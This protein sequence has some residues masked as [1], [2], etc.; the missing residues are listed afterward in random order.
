MS[1]TKKLEN[2]FQEKFNEKVKNIETLKGDGSDRSLFRLISQTRSVIGV[3]GKNRKENVAFVKFSKIF[4]QKGI[5]VPEIYIEDLDNDMYLEEDLGDDT[6]YSWMSEIREKEGF[7]D[8]I[9]KMYGKVIAQLPRIQIQAGKDIDYTLCYQHTEFGK[10]SMMWDMH[11]FKWNLLNLFYKLDINNEKLEEEFNKLTDFLLEEKKDFFLFRDFQSRN[12]MI[13]NKEPFFIDYQSGRKGALEYDL[14]SML[15]DS[16]AN[17]PQEIREKL[18]GKYITSTQEL[19]EIDEG[20]FK[21]YFYG[22]ALIRIM[23]ALGAYGFLGRVKNRPHFLGNIPFAIANLEIILNK[24]NFLQELPELNNI[25]QNLCSDNSLRQTKSQSEL[26]VKI[27]SFGYHFSGIPQ[28][29]K[30]EHNGGF[31]FDLRSLPNPGREEN[32]RHLTGQD[33]LVKEFLDKEERTQKYLKHV[34]ELI[35]MAIDNYKKR[36]FTDLMV[37]FGCTG[38]QHRSIYFAE[39]LREYIEKKE[40]QVN[41]KHVDLEK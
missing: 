18:I 29:E 41:L 23:Q 2:L 1:D 39:K 15:Y 21:K 35:D 7:S 34:F 19:V 10:E 9:F 12:V 17:I 32:L 27:Y 5:N 33:R 40:I 36:G 6:L 14:A 30:E 25:I 4:K 28:D 37:S 11:Y 26:V 13:K 20:K 3:I 24:F 8:K 22:F 38:G 31:V 16:K